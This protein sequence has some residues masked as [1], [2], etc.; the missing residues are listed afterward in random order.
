M[1]KIKTGSS[2]PADN[3]TRLRLASAIVGTLTLAACASA[4]LAP[5][6]ELQAAELA[7]ANAEKARV[8]DYAA[9][10]LGEARDKLAAARVAVQQEKMG[11]AQQLA[12][13]SRVD[14][15]LAAAKSSAVRAKL[16]NDEM[17]KSTDAIKQEMQR[18]PGAAK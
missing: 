17:L 15:D 3:H 13:Q 11:K 2:V 14:A 4:P 18:N 5:T 8:A 7:I 12:E 6:Q 9:P 1:I 16:V 10:E